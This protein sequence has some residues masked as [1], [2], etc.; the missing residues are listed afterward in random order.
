MGMYCG[1]LCS[2]LWPKHWLPAS[3][4]RAVMGSLPLSPCEL[5][6]SV[7]EKWTGPRRAALPGRWALAAVD[8]RLSLRPQ[9]I[10]VS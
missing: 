10:A 3:Q 4:E 7:C 5:R 9:C 1:H 8:S 6:A 2:G